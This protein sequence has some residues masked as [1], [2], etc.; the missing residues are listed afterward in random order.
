MPDSDGCLER[1]KPG[2]VGVQVGGAPIRQAVP[3]FMCIVSLSPK[4]I[5]L[6][7]LCKEESGTQ[8]LYNLLKMAQQASGRAR[9]QISVCLTPKPAA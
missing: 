7:S 6:L 3:D 8:R 5:L 2:K 9:I 1:G 4:A